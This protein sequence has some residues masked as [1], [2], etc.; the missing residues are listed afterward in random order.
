MTI[1]DQ[2]KILDRKIKQNEAQ[3]GLDRR[4]AKISALSS[5]N[6]DKYEYLTGEDLNYE[7]STVEQAKF[8]YS[9]L[10]KFFNRGLKEEKKKDF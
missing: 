9:P 6:L 4:A 8:D 5:G 1:T 10:S 2:I 7:P 3:Y